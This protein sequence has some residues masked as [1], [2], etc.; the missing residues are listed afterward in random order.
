MTESRIVFQGT[1][2]FSLGAT[3]QASANAGTDAVEVRLYVL[4]KGHLE[5]VV[6]QMVPTVAHMLA[7]EL[8]RAALQIESKMS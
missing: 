7:T 8:S 1:A 5:P 2:P 3:Q 4:H 6:T